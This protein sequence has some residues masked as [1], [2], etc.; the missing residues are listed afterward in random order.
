MRWRL[1]VCWSSEATAEPEK[2]HWTY[3]ICQRYCLTAA[4]GRPTSLLSGYIEWYYWLDDTCSGKLYLDNLWVHHRFYGTVLWGVRWDW[5]MR[6]WKKA[7]NC[8]LERAQEV[9]AALFLANIS[10][11]I[12]WLVIS[13]RLQ[14]CLRMCHDERLGWILLPWEYRE[15][16]VKWERLMPHQMELAGLLSLGFCVWWSGGGTSVPYLDLRHSFDRSCRLNLFANTS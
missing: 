9:M 7:R 14:C 13:E 16:L 12:P 10:I 1:T 8:W 6:D 5:Q 2:P 3:D 11:I 4:Y 15:D